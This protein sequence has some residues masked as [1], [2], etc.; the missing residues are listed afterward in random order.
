MITGITS[1]RRN[2]HEILTP[3]HAP[4]GEHWRYGLGFP[5]QV[6]PTQ[7]A[8]FANIH[9]VSAA[10]WDYEAGTDGLIFDDLRGLIPEVAIPLSRNHRETHPATGKKVTMVKNPL[11]G[12]FV[13]I[14]AKHADGSPHPHAGTGFGIALA[15]AHDASTD[16]PLAHDEPY[17]YFELSQLAF[18]G[19]DLRVTKTERIQFGDL[20]PGV[21]LTNL[22]LGPAVPDGDDFLWAMSANPTLAGQAGLP[23]GWEETSVSGVARW[24]R[25]SQGWRPI[26]FT[27]VSDIPSAEPSLV[28]DGDGALLFT[29]RPYRPG[30]LYD[31]LIWRSA[32]GGRTWKQILAVPQLRQ[33]SP[34]SLGQAADGTPYFV[35]NQSLASF[36]NHQGQLGRVGY[37][38]HREILSLWPLNAERTSF[39]TP[40]FVRIPRYEF[41]PPR[42]GNEWYCDH[43][44]G[45]TVR[46]GNGQW[47]H[48]LCYRI[49]AIA[50]GLG[51]GFPPTPHSGLHVSEIMSAGPSN[52]PWRF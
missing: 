46:L 45:V 14:G 30:N 9:R 25:G 33:P 41:G 12:G 48:L 40:H 42:H 7:A 2:L 34:L 19:R 37:V 1:V 52:P 36:I 17:A 4:A 47:H 6:S 51:Q 29:A 27:V 15:I 3:P 13:P 23:F 22:G 8:I 39:L 49:M 18:D 38:T 31:A 32:D 20:L 10:T 11:L 43:P 50:E 28:R 5:L 26:E 35:C 21:F 16:L 24:R 44:V